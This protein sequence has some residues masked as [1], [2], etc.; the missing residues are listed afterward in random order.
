MHGNTTG[1]HSSP[2]TVPVLHLISMEKQGFLLKLVLEAKSRYGKG[3][4]Q[5]PA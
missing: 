3:C 5:N 1:D 4:V 2:H